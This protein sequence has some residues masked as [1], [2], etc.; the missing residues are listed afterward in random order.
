[1]ERARTKELEECAKQLATQAKAEAAKNNSALEIMAL[2]GL[3]T[4]RSALLLAE[5]AEWIDKGVRAAA[6]QIGDMK[7]KI[8]AASTESTNVARGIRN[9]TWWLVTAAIV[10]A[11]ATAVNVLVA[12]LK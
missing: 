12:I 1:M 6:I 2:S 8:K 11:G 4:A 10:T 7:K 3:A 9:L 5:T